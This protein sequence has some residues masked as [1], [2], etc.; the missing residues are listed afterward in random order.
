MLPKPI[1]VIADSRGRHL[2]A[3]LGT[4]FT[5]LDFNIV[6]RGGLRLDQAAD[7]AYDAILNTSPRI[8]YVLCGIC[9]ITRLTQR[10]PNRVDLCRGSVHELVMR[11]MA[12]LDI[13]MSQIFALQSI[14]GHYIMVVFPTQTGMS[15][16]RYNQFPPGLHHPM[17]P[18]LNTA[19]LRINREVTALNY[20]MAI[21]TPFLGTAVHPRRYHYNRFI[22]S[23]LYDGC[24]PSYRLTY[25]WARRLYLNALSNLD[26]YES[27][28]LANALY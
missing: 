4:V 26:R 16:A 19:I 27:Q 2:R 7:F 24:H 11:Y 8:V 6:W 5:D 21:R 28:Q 10:R 17:Q 3:S 14:V 15:L 20:S 9:D 1:L 12:H 18:I 13:A 22:Y 25:Y 23:R